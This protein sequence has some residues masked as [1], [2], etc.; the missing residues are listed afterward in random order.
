MAFCLKTL[1]K[2]KSCCE[3]F[4]TKYSNERNV[5]QL[6]FRIFLDIQYLCQRDLVNIYI[7]YYNINYCYPDFNGHIDHDLKHKRSIPI[8]IS[9]TNELLAPVENIF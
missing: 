9:Q 3:I 2:A 5:R 7:G 4:H 6:V 8:S 1:R